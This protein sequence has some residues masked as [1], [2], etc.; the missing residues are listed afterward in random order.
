MSSYPRVS[1][2]PGLLSAFLSLPPEART[3]LPSCF[4]ARSPP[5]VHFGPVISL[6]VPSVAGRPVAR[7]RR[8]IS[9]RAFPAANVTLLR[10]A[11]QTPPPR[12]RVS[13]GGP[14]R[15]TE[16]FKRFVTSS[17]AAFRAGIFRIRFARVLPHFSR[18]MA[19]LSS[20]SVP[21]CA[22]VFARSSTGHRLE[23]TLK[24]P[25]F[26]EGH[27][28]IADG[29]RWTRWRRLKGIQVSLSKQQSPCRR[30]I[31]HRAPIFDAGIPF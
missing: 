6:A 23:K 5:S 3:L 25:L 9:R 26:P 14:P 1:F 16:T 22:S 7:A 8:R 29:T 12:I 24:L 20:S 2:H 19:H 31:V 21:A 10:S 15:I 4:L 11:K 17:P 18:T 28:N 27:P 30:S 13:F